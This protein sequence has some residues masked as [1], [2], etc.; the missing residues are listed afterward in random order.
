[1]RTKRRSS[2]SAPPLCRHISATTTTERPCCRPEPRDT[3]TPANG[4]SSNGTWFY[5]PAGGKRMPLGRYGLLIGALACLSFAAGLAQT[6]PPPAPAAEQTEFFEKRVRPV[7]AE[8]CYNCHG[9][10][11]QFG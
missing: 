7:L 3:E 2:Q 11:M 8:R 5:S 1:M 6:A 9:S 10:R 4:L